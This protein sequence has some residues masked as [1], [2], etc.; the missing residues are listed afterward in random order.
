[1]EKVG[2]GGKGL[3]VAS[4]TH[5]SAAPFWCSTTLQFGKH[6]GAA[7]GLQRAKRPSPI[8]SFVVIFVTLSRLK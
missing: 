3:A 2:G 4:D 7:S 8:V 5:G 6:V 1:M